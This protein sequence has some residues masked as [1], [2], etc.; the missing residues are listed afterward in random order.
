M[1]SEV[2]FTAKIAAAKLS[3][4]MTNLVSTKTQ[5]MQAATFVAQHMQHN[6]QAVGASEEALDVG[7]VD[8]SNATGGDYAVLLFNRDTGLNYVEVKY[9]ITAGPTYWIAAKLLAGECFLAGRVPKLDGSSLG[10]IYL[11]SSSG[12]QNVESLVVEM[13][14]PTL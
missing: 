1:A 7:D 3:V 9:K 8:I 4:S 6:V 5:N 2:Q 10:G 11:K 13:G 12:T 14:D